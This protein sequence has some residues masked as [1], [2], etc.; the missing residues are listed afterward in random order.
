[1]ADYE[2][3]VEFRGEGARAGARLMREIIRTPAFLE[4]IKTNMVALDPEGARMAV[5]TVLWEDPELTLS[6][7]STVPEVINYL[8]EAVVELGRQ[9]GQFPAPLLDAFLTQLVSGIDTGAMR[10]APVVYGPLLEKVG[11][12][13]K[14]VTAFGSAMNAVARAINRTAAKNPYFV[15][16]SLEAVDGRE[17]GRAAWAVTRSLAL[18]GFSAAAKV[19][20]RLAGGKLS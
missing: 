3:S 20:R 12:Q 14:A 11:F 18:W 4:I 17:V 13:Q 7:A 9:L 6:I 16:D 1:M 8:V 2:G 19:F 5:R 15:R 10:E